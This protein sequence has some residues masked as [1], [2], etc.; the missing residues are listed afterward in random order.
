MAVNKHLNILDF[1]L[2]HMKGR[3]FFILPEAFILTAIV[4]IASSIIFLV[5]SLKKESEIILSFSP[6]ITVQ[7]MISD[8]HT[9]IPSDISK[10]IENIEGVK[11]VRARVWSYYNEKYSG[12]NFTLY[13]ISKESARELAEAKIN[14]KEGGLFNSDKKRN[15]V[16]G[17]GVARV[18]DLKGRRNLTLC[19]SS[20]ELRNYVIS[21]IFASSSALF[22]S[23]LII[24]S[25]EDLKEFLKI[26]KDRA[27]DIIVYAANPV[28]IPI[29][30]MKISE[31]RPFL[32]TITRSQ[33]ERNYKALFNFRGQIILFAWL[34]CFAAFLIILWNKS[35]VGNYEENNELGIL[36]ALGWGAEDV[37]E[38]KIAESFISGFFSFIVGLIMAYMHV[39]LSGAKLF[40]PV[41]FGWSVLYP[42]FKLYPAISFS[43]LFLIFI[44]TILPYLSVSLVPAWKIASI[45]PMDLIRG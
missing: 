45:D 35:G 2:S 32:K 19:D 4:F 44:L 21:G 34:G 30:A 38:M 5:N 6:E 17:E 26:P 10:E 8:L 3:L 25:E 28:E 7:C 41:L 16:V 14:F 13:G 37:F 36:K 31:K 9:L 42:E 20:G 39:Y 12:A 43:S 18:L 33:V 22:T 27:T 24:F 15:I 29:I 1:K 40:K 23:D 11:S